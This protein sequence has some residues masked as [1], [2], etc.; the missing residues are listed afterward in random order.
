[1]VDLNRLKG[2]E[3]SAAMRGGTEGWG[4]Q[5][6]V[7]NIK[8]SVQKPKAAGRCCGC[9]CGCKSSITHLGMANGVCLISGCEFSVKL[10][11]STGRIKA[12][13]NFRRLSGDKFLPV[14]LTTKI[15]VQVPN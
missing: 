1:M 10:W 9:S 11:V 2:S 4:K 7:N 8:Y 6:S 15:Q 3:L 14:R 5:G 12:M 13:E